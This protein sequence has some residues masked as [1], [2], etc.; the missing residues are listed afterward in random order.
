MAPY[1]STFVL[2][3]F[4]ADSDYLIDTSMFSLELS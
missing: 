2:E 4:T 3:Y 1:T